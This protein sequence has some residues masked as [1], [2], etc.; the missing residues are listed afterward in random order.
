MNEPEKSN[1]KLP[2]CPKCGCH[3]VICTTVKTVFGRQPGYECRLCYYMWPKNDRLVVGNQDE[4][5]KQIF[6][7]PTDCLRC[8]SRSVKVGYYNK[9]F[10]WARCLMCG[11]SWVLSKR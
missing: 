5:L 1:A 4:S 11:N 3:D 2:P 10:A 8:H 9:D 7:P 6:G